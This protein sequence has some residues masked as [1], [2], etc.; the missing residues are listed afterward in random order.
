MFIKDIHGKAY[1][2]IQRGIDFMKNQKHVQILNIVITV[3]I[4]IILLFIHG[5]GGRVTGTDEEIS[6]LTVIATVLAIWCFVST[7]LCKIKITNLYTI[8]LIFYTVFIFG[9]MISRTFFNYLPNESLYLYRIVDVTYISKAIILATYCM[10]GMHIG[11]N[12]ANLLKKEETEEEIEDESKKQET[13]KVIRIV[14]AFLI[15]I[16]VIPAISNFIT[17]ARLAYQ[18]GYESVYSDKNIGLGSISEKLEPFSFLGLLILM[19]SYKDNLK[20]ARII[21]LVNLLYNGLQI[22]FGARGVPII[23][24][25]VIIITYHICIQKFKTSY[26]IIAAIL[27]TPLFNMLSMIK[28]VRKYPIEEWVANIGTIWEETSK[29]QP[30]LTV[31]NE[32]GTAIFPTAAALDFYPAQIPYK[33]GT[34]YLYG[35]LSIVPNI[36]SNE[37]HIAARENVATEVS[38]HYGARFGGSIVED[39]Y[40]NFGWFAP[41]LFI[42]IG[43]S[44]FKIS[45]LAERKYK[46]N[47]IIYPL[48]AF[49]AAS[50]LWTTRN[51]INPIFRDFVWYVLSTYIFYK[52]VYKYLQKNGGFKWK[53]KKYL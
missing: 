4:L 11:A 16:S 53:G 30:I 35:I 6:S 49:I 15:I 1:K 18:G 14:A 22:F 19:V 52:L 29:E 39:V 32:M 44:L 24:C 2:H 41:I 23:N 13:I 10:L 51:T 3:L 21:F 7:I 48:Y 27:I 36:N 28:E 20:N 8:Y 12:I 17:D 46:N 31:M 50:I 25:I 40:A 26:I 42:A 34:T 9:A 47:F 5:F 33:Y 37:V 38:E 45:E 43:F